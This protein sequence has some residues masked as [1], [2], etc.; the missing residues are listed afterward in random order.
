[1]KA[2]VFGVSALAG[3]ICVQ[4]VSAMS[5]R[6]AAERAL[7]NDPRMQAADSAVQSSR[8]G[9]DEAKAGYRPTVSLAASVAAQGIHLQSDLPPGIVLPDVMN[10]AA[11]S[12][13]ASQP[14]YSGG[15]TDANIKS[16]QQALASSEQAETET[17]QGLLLETATAYLE[18]A[19]DRG[20]AR[21]VSDLE[22]V[23]RDGPQRGGA[24][25][26]GAEH[27]D[28][29]DLAA[30]TRGDQPGRRRS[31]WRTKR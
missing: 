17:R 11:L 2:F 5:L 19:R 16:S 23:Y 28:A 25:S 12:L 15:L 22:N 6:E 9:V 4:P 26:V 7:Q 27:D 21:L 24:P 31:I 10:P 8:A 30:G 13:H 20:R 18:V 14:L 29:N 1:M 3:A